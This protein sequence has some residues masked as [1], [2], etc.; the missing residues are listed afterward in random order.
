MDLRQLEY[1]Q[2]VA[3][4]KTPLCRSVCRSS[5]QV[6]ENRPRFRIPVNIEK[7]ISSEIASLSQ[8]QRVKE[9]EQNMLSKGY[10][11]TAIDLDYAD[12]M[13]GIEFEKL[14]GKIFTARGFKVDFTSVTGDMGAD[15]IIEKLGERTAIQAKCYNSLVSGDSVQQVLA[16]KAIYN[17]QKAIVVTNSY[18]T[19]GAKDLAVNSTRTRDKVYQDLALKQNTIQIIGNSKANTPPKM[20]GVFALCDLLLTLIL[21]ILCAFI[22]VVIAKVTGYLSIQF[23][24]LLIA[25][26]H[27]LLANFYVPFSLLTAFGS[28]LFASIDSMESIFIILPAENLR[29]FFK[30]SNRRP[31]HPRECTYR[32]W[33][34][35]PSTKENTLS[36]GRLSLSF[37]STLIK[38]R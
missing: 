5:R 1:F 20:D 38:A 35:C 36:P 30:I 10:R 6:N 32:Y 24:P 31:I 34:F 9:I 15:L 21:C 25:F 29:A 3:K 8:A 37:L 4:L 16:S 14:L 22:S 27:N 7:L 2:M 26:S 11:G 23:R 33:Q 13:S 17:C 18:F 19:K 12:T 28:P